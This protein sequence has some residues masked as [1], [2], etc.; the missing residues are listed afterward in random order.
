MGFDAEKDAQQKAE[1][2]RQI[3][4]AAFRVF[5]ERT[6]EKVTM[7]DIAEAAGVGVASIYRYYGSKSALVV[8]VSTHAWTQYVNERNSRFY[9]DGMT[10]KGEMAYFLDAFLDL[11]RNHKDLLRFNQFFNVYVQS[12]AVTPEQMAPYMQMIG[13][14]KDRFHNV[15]EKGRGDGTLRTGDTTER[16][17]FSAVVHLMLAAVTRYA[18]GL[19]FTDGAD[20]A[21]ELRLARNLLLARYTT[22]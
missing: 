18:V 14:L 13:M 3:L 1:T 8:A 11:Y 7:T 10:G 2:R 9:P 20:P 4:A 22:A 6:I 19:V 15:Y 16:E 5:A 17:M 21:Q 12:E